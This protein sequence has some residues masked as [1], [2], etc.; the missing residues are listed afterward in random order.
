[1]VSAAAIQPLRY[2]VRLEVIKFNGSP[3]AGVYLIDL[4]HSGAKLET[5]FPL[6]LQYPVEFSFC[7]PGTSSEIM[8]SGRVVW[9]QQLT[10][11]LL[12]YHL[13]VEFHSPRWDLDTLL[14][15]LVQNQ[16]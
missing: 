5:T 14:R 1:M 12:G 6:S 10:D 7:L 8:V 2:R 4:D 13:G 3:G 11:P 16:G 9:K 15:N